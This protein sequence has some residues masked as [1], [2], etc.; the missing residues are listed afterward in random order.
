MRPARWAFIS[1][2]TIILTEELTMGGGTGFGVSRFSKTRGFTFALICVASL[3]AGCSKSEPETKADNGVLDTSRLPRLSGAKEIFASPASTMFTSTDPVPQA[4]DALEKALAAAGWQK[5]VAPHT[6]YSQ[7]AALRI[8]SLKKGAQGLSVMITVAPAQK[9]ATSVQYSAIALSGD[10]PFEKDATD[11]EFD[12][13]R[14]LLTLITAQPIDKTLD[15]YR[16][17]LAI[18]SLKTWRTLPTSVLNEAFFLAG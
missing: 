18:I 6:A 7:E 11:I 16:K 13:N 17:E 2:I 8:L 14:S 9:N 4:A 5:Y 10:L 15:F 1:A 12:P 3:A